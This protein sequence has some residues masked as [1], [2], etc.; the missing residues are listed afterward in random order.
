MFKYECYIKKNTI[1]LID[2][3][4]SFGYKK[5][6]IFKADDSLITNSL[7][8]FISFSSKKEQ[9]CG[10]WFIDCEKSE[11]AFLAIA[12]IRN[13]NDWFQWFT[14]KKAEGWYQHVKTYDMDKK[15]VT[16]NSAYDILPKDLWHKATPKEILKN[17]K[18]L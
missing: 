9:I 3:L 8:T 4:L 13:D 16:P 1:E 5:G 7:G 10:N 18:G 12:A 17:F 15:Q 11:T 2:K 6:I 14:T